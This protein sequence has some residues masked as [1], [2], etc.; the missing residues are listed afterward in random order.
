MLWR[1]L[2]TEATTEL[3]VTLQLPGRAPAPEL[4]VR[5]VGELEHLDVI[6]PA[7]GAEIVL[8]SLLPAIRWRDPGFA[9]TYRLTLGAD[10]RHRPSG[11]A[12]TVVPIPRSPLE[13]VASSAE[14]QVFEIDLIAH[15]GLPAAVWHARV[16][17]A[18]STHL[19]FDGMWL[20]LEMRGTIGEPP[21]LQSVSPLVPVKLRF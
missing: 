5:F 20:L 12:P 17:H 14:G 9:E 4:R 15:F 7:A 16:A 3:E 21:W 18:A 11:F 19:N 8:G 2:E 1:W 6:A 13:P 10:E